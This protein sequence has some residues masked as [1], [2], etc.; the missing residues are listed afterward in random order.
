M[1]FYISAVIVVVAVGIFAYGRKEEWQLSSHVGYSILSSYKIVYT[2]NF[3]PAFFEF[4]FAS[5]IIPRHSNNLNPKARFWVM[6]LNC[7]FRSL[8]SQLPLVSELL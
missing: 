4:R 8:L 1:T 7:F 6:W 3:L 5:L 2:G